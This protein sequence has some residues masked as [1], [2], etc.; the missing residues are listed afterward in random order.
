MGSNAVARFS[1]GAPD[2]KHAAKLMLIAFFLFL[3]AKSAV[4]GPFSMVCHFPS[5]NCGSEVT[6]IVSDRFTSRYPSSKWQIV[7][8]AEFTPYS[9]GGGVGYAIAGVSRKISS[10]QSATQALVPHQRFVSTS[11]RVGRNILASEAV[12]ETI[13]LVRE[14][15]EQMVVACENTSNCNVE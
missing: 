14:A 3:A 1:I 11:R 8:L 7:V 12:E 5:K 2:M 10:P 15:L 9:N 4:A 13:Q 6:D